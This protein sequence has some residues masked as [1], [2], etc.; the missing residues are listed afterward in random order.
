MGENVRRA[1][2]LNDSFELAQVGAARMADKEVVKEGLGNYL[3]GR[4]PGRRDT[5]LSKH[6]ERAARLLEFFDH[7]A[8]DPPDFFKAAQIGNAL[9]VDPAVAG[10]VI[11]SLVGVSPINRKGYPTDKIYA[12]LDELEANDVVL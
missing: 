5:A 10:K 9:G 1:F 8:A 6:D 2:L 4:G 3:S 12:Y 7:H 11:Q